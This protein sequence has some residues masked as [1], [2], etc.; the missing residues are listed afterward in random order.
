ML[1]RDEI[2]LASS[3]IAYAGHNAIFP[4]G[5]IKMYSRVG[6]HEI[7]GFKTDQ[8]QFIM[9]VL[10]K[11]HSWFMPSLV[12]LYKEFPSLAKL[13]NAMVAAAEKF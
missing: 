2:A 9:V 4:E 5:Q 12:Q 3:A 8:G 6:R 10:A 11:P 13:T 1:N 7:V